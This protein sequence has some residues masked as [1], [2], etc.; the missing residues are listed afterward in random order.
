MPAAKHRWVYVSE[1]DLDQSAPSPSCIGAPEQEGV[2]AEATLAS[3][4]TLVLCIDWHGVLDRGWDHRRR[5]FFPVA[6]AAILNVC[7]ES[8]AD[9]CHSVL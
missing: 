3:R 8:A 6:R 9:L 4:D 1:A 2:V 7:Q 5:V